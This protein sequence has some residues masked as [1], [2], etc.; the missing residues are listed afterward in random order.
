MPTEV[1]GTCCCISG[2]A[3]PHCALGFY[4]EYTLVCSSCGTESDHECCPELCG[5]HVLKYRG[6]SESSGTCCWRP[7]DDLDCGDG[8]Y[9][10]V[11]HSR[12]VVPSPGYVI[13]LGYVAQCASM[14]NGVT[15]LTT[16]DC[17][18]PLAGT[19]PSGFCGASVS[20]TLTA[21]GTFVDC[22]EGF[23]ALAAAAAA[24]QK[25][26][27]K[28]C[29]RRGPGWHLRQILKSVGIEATEAGCGCRSLAARMD[30]GGVQWCDRN[31]AEIVA[32]LREN[33]AKLGWAARLKAAALSVGSGLAFRLDPLDPA[34]GLLAEAI[35]RAEAADPGQSG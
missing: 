1:V 11:L 28:A 18:E 8:S 35:R 19:D 2:C 13:V 23:A 30:R 21:T 29:P 3:C 32:R 14:P 22:S 6:D 26:A 17:L 4:T 20:W 34:P 10:W 16:W 9:A 15:N 24:E 25:A 31:A 27:R 7:D 12:P 5:T 33:Y